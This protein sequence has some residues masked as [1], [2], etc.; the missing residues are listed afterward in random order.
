MTLTSKDQSLSTTVDPRFNRW[1]GRLFGGLVL[2]A[3]LLY[4]IGS[5]LVE[6]PIGLVLALANSVA[7]ATVGVIGL[8]AVRPSGTSLG[9]DRGCRSGL[10]CGA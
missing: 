1:E 3:F 2:S 8:R 10:P 4:G 5:A 6:E 7:V 9:E